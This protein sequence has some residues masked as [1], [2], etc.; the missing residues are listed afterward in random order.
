MSQA[1]WT[2]HLA[3]H[4]DLD[5]TRQTCENATCR[6]S[7]GARRFFLDLRELQPNLQIYLKENRLL[8]AQAASP[9]SHQKNK[10]LNCV[11]I[12]EPR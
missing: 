6:P 1:G 7:V 4:K 5:P 9:L 3:H 10:A 2:T 12:V 11:V 8:W